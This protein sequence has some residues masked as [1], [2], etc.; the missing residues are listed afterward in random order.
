[1]RW[2]LV[3]GALLLL[4]PPGISANAAT[5]SAEQ[6][7]FPTGQFPQDVQNVQA[8]LDGG[9]RVLLKAVDVSGVPTPFEFATTGAAFLSSDVT[10]V[11]E[12]VANAMTTIHG[13]LAPFRSTAFVPVRSAFHGLHFDGPR[14]TAVFLNF[15]AGLDFSGNVVTDVIGAPYVFG[16]TKGQAVWITA[17]PGNVT[18]T[19]TIAGNAV[20]R[21]YA[22]LS[23]GV[24]I[25]GF[26]ATA[27]I[28]DN[29]FHDTR[30][31]A[32]LVVDGSQTIWIEDNLVVPGAAP[33]PGFFSLGNGIFVGQGAGA[34]YIR[35]NTVVCGNPFADGIALSGHTALPNKVPAS[36]VVEHN[37]VTMHDSLFGAITIYGQIDPALIANNQ[38]RGDGAHALQIAAAFGNERT[39]GVVFRGNNLAGFASTVADVFLDSISYETVLVG[40]SGTVVDLGTDNRI[41][42]FAPTPLAIGPELRAAQE[43]KRALLQRVE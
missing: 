3:V 12:T 37:D 9:G 1:V 33:Y 39:R 17:A 8:A 10:V 18:G 32:I 22:D 26:D 21:V 23:Y 16:L 19:V 29:R 28:A 31:T 38:V 42:G 4:A 40:H 11:G 14:S 34:A 27:R 36:S 41:T 25:A 7:V 30:D 20:E 24:A 5:G 43:R 2:N 15:S 35:R 13:G 6:V